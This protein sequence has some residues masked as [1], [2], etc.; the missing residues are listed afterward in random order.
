MVQ[1][2]KPVRSR[3]RSAAAGPEAELVVA[4]YDVVRHSRRTSGSEVLEPAATV[5]LAAVARLD[6]ARP[7]DIACDIRLDLS[8]VSR[9]LGHLERNGYV[10]RSEDPADGRARRVSPTAQGRAALDQVVTA[11][12]ALV[13]QALAQWSPDDRATLTRLLRRLADDMDAGSPERPA[14]TAPEAP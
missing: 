4:L 5:V 11:R 12:S 10:A 1:A 8:T 14:T 7:S 2:I 13:N 6:P 9:H 3:R